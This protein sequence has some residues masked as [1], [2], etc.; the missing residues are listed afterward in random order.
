MRYMQKKLIY[1]Y[2][3]N[4][5]KIDNILIKLKKQTKSFYNR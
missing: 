3:K 5:E 2:D 1:F 4:V